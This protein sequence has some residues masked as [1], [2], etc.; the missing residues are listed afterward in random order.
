VTAGGITS[1]RQAGAGCGEEYLKNVETPVG[2]VRFTFAKSSSQN[3]RPSVLGSRAV[4]QSVA[5]DPDPPIYGLKLRVYAYEYTRPEVLAG[6]L[7]CHRRL[8]QWAQRGRGVPVQAVAIQW[9]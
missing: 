9:R 2:V 4:V 3:L 7:R 6:R 8:H 5:A 1:G